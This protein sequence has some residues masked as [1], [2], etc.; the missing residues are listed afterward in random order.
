MVV[1]CE[2][3]VAPA[4]H[5]VLN[6]VC[7]ECRVYADDGTV[8]TLIRRNSERACIQATLKAVLEIADGILDGTRTVRPLERQVR[9]WTQYRENFGNWCLLTPSEIGET[10]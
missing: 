3:D 8:L 2:L 6:E 4:G 9:V 10:I 5:P 7:W 1:D